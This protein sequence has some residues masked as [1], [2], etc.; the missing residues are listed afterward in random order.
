M[1]EETIIRHC[2]PTLAGLKTGNLFTCSYNTKDEI[3][4]QISCLNRLLSKKGL[5]ILPMRLE[6]GK[7]LIYM[8][9]PKK[10]IQDFTDENARTLLEQLGYKYESPNICVTKLCKKLCSQS[11]FPHEIGLF[12]GYPPKD[13]KGFIE[14]KAGD[15][16]LL[17]C[18]KVYDD[19]QKA[20]TLFS[21]YKKCSMV[22]YNQWSNGKPID[23]LTVKI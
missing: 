6:Q 11:D 20:Q 9:R 12:L 3:I 19:L 16:K 15:C 23:R 22:Y 10:L 7:A 1:S 17:G 14:N 18:W 5:R 4:R 13:V 8:Y 21:R 2:A